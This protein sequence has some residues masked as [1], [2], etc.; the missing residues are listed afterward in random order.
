MEREEQ[1]EADRR[2]A[3]LDWAK[4]QCR[5]AAHAAA[6]KSHKMVVFSS[7][8]LEMLKFFV[9]VLFLLEALGQVRWCM[10]N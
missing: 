8:V 2:T 10:G 6:K 3:N 1:A 5:S 4:F 7:F 9:F